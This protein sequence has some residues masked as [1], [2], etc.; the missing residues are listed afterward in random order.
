[1]HAWLTHA[2]PVAGHDLTELSAFCNPAQPPHSDTSDLIIHYNSHQQFLQYAR[3]L[4]PMLA[5]I[6]LGVSFCPIFAVLQ[7]L[8]YA[9]HMSA[10]VGMLSAGQGPPTVL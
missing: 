8:V 1:M 9:A 6:S 5:D 7:C 4:A 10:C 2:V 3:Q